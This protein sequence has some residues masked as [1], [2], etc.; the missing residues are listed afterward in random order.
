MGWT[1]SPFPGRRNLGR[2]A[3]RLAEEVPGL[4]PWQ[5]PRGAV[6][7]VSPATVF[8]PTRGWD[9]SA[10]GRG[11]RQQAGCGQSSQLWL[12][13][14]GSSFL[15]NGT[16]RLQTSFPTF[17]FFSVC[18]LKE[19]PS[20]RNRVSSW[21]THSLQAASQLTDHLHTIYSEKKKSRNFSSLRLRR[22]AVREVWFLPCSTNKYS[23]CETEASEAEQEGTGSWLCSWTLA[24]GNPT[25]V[26]LGSGQQLRGGTSEKAQRVSPVPGKRR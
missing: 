5:V 23:N 21:E 14:I 22:R 24:T 15:C 3:P 25:W 10:R 18:E 19:Q 4:R 8:V 9:V 2:W 26:P 20:Q 17:F 16:P 6:P 7:S 1:D 11:L 12:A 13:F